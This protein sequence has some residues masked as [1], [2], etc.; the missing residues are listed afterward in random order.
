[1]GN[2]SMAEKQFLGI[3]GLYLILI[4]GVAGLWG[5][6][7]ALCQAEELLEVK[8]LWLRY[9]RSKAHLA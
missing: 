3:R 1:M 9:L 7:S 6:S 2:C 8:P 5:L 4:L